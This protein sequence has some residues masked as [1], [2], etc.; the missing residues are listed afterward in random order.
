MRI[1][2]YGPFSF[3]A[4]GNGWKQYYIKGKM[5]QIDKNGKVLIDT[6]KLK[7]IRRIMTDTFKKENK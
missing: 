5:L 3:I 1:V 4:Q 7:E 6:S 2:R